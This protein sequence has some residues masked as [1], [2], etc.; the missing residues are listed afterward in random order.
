MATQ[1]QGGVKTLTTNTRLGRKRL[2]LTNTLAYYRHERFYK[3]IRGGKEKTKKIERKIKNFV[4][5]T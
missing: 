4:R 5:T 2:A 3:Q 1:S